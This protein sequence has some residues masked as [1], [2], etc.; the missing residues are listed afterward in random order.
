MST[1]LLNIPKQSFL[2]SNKMNPN[3]LAIVFSPNMF[4]CSDGIEGFKEQS[5]TNNI[6]CMFIEDYDVIL[7]VIKQ[8]F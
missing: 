7:K 2:D 5:V 3:A 6:V 8:L 1:T 4:R